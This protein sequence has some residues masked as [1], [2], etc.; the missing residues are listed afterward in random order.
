MWE[1]KVFTHFNF[2]FFFFLLFFVLFAIAQLRRENTWVWIAGEYKQKYI[3]IQ[4]CAE[5]E[6]GI[7]RERERERHSRLHSVQ[8]CI[9][10]KCHELDCNYANNLIIFLNCCINS[11]RLLCY[12]HCRSRLYVRWFVLEWRKSGW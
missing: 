6:C 7:E 3:H 12:F 9:M 11:F 4:N 2:R 8:L 5:W 10:L 1:E